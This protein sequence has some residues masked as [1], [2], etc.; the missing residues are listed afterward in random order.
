MHGENVS[1]K[2]LCHYKMMLLT[3]C[4]SLV[5]GKRWLVASRCTNDVCNPRVVGVFNIFVKSPDFALCRKPTGTF[6]IQYYASRISSGRRQK[7]IQR[8]QL[9]GTLEDDD[10]DSR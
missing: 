10:V 7:R 3:C 6:C 5:V 9:I 4:S 8:A 2:D 1:E